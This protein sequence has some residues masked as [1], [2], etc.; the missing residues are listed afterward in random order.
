MIGLLVRETVALKRAFECEH[1]WA[2]YVHALPSNPEDQCSKCGI[3]ATPAGKIAL[4]KI[5]AGHSR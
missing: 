3:I 1:E 5:A 2:P 4:Q